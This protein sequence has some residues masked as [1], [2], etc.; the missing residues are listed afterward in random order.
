[1]ALP[2][3]HNATS[4]RRRFDTGTPCYAPH[5]WHNEAPG[6]LPT[7]LHGIRILQFFGSGVQTLLQIAEFCHGVYEFT[8]P[9]PPGTF[10][11]MTSL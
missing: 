11:D 10:G 3:L 4:A 7:L 1:M 9:L 8:V 2:P 5:E 6:S